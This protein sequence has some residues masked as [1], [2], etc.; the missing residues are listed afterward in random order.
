RVRSAM[1]PGPGQRL[2]L[3][4]GSYN[5]N[6]SPNL[7]DTDEWDGQTW[8]LRGTLPGPNHR[9]SHAMVY[10]ALRDRTLLFGGEGA[11]DVE[12]LWGYVQPHPPQ[13]DQ[14]PHDAVACSGQS[15]TFTISASSLDPIQYQWRRG[16]SPIA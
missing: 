16:G 12:E 8:T 3:F 15:V 7:S 14:Q 11:A 5:G 10:D 9:S 1:A 2:V 4:S 13:V 6:T